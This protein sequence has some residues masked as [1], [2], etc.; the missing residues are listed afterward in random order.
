MQLSF[1]ATDS[2]SNN[3]VD[4]SFGGELIERIQPLQGTSFQNYNL[5]LVAGTGDRSNQLEFR[6]IVPED[7]V[8]VSL[9]GIVVN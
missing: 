6:G 9:H 7:S 3:A 8:S 1:N 2:S 5:N 4:I